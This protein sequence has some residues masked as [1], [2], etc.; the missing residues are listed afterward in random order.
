MNMKR[1]INKGMMAV[2]AIALMMTSCKKNTELDTDLTSAEDQSN[3]EMV[4]DLV[5]KQVDDAASDQG[6]K[7][8]GY[9]IIT[10]DT[11]ANPRTM[12][13]YYGDVNY[14]CKD[15]NYRRG[16]IMVSWTGKYRN[17]GTIINISFDKFYQNDYH[18][19]GTKSITNGGRNASG[20]LFFTIVVDGKVTGP[21]GLAHTW[22][23]NRTRT[24][25]AGE[26]TQNPL[27]DVYEISGNTSGVNRKGV[28]YNAN[29]TKNL[30]VELGCEWRITSGV[31]EITPEGKAVRT[32]D[33][34]NGA[35]DRLVT[36]TINGKSRTFERR[37]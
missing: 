12:T 25:I 6:V 22:K 1:L 26:L 18:V 9:P 14:L 37:K 29:I 20:N 27:D 36:V 30:R 23:S 33:F 2:I 4:Y 5:Y 24:W 7:K 13:V 34:G 11:V 16:T 19:E 21:D 28:G 10:I 3:G 32:V 17:S 35:C 31:I 15:G 8:G